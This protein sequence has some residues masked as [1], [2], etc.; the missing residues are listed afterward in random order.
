M[1]KAAEGKLRLW[2]NRIEYPVTG[3]SHRHARSARA[4]GKHGFSAEPRQ[5]RRAF[6]NI[7]RPGAGSLSYANLCQGLRCACPRLT[8]MLRGG[9]LNRSVNYVPKRG[10]YRRIRTCES[11]RAY[12]NRCPRQ[13]LRCID[14]G[15]AA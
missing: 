7:F 14:P 4:P 3:S 1:Q 13:C 11:V 2:L 10:L 9:D 12:I 6:V 15:F 8:F 5:G